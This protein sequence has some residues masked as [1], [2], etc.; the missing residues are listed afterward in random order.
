MKSGAAGGD[1]EALPP[2]SP[3]LALS[4]VRGYCRGKNHDRIVPALSLADIVKDN[5]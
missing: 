3:S 4:H 1:D 2:L 5:G